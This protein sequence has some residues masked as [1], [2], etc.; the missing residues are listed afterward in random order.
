MVLCVGDYV[1][2]FDRI[3]E[4]I[5]IAKVD[6]DRAIDIIYIA[7]AQALGSVVEQRDLAM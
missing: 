5:A 6:K 1:S 3:F 4:V 2:E 7:N